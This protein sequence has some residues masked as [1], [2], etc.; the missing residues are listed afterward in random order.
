MLS[1]EVFS[2]DCCLALSRRLCKNSPTAVVI[3][4]AA[5]WRQLGQAGSLHTHL[6][7]T[8][9]Q[10]PTPPRGGERR[11]LVGCVLFSG[12]LSRSGL[13]GSW[14]P[15]QE[16]NS[17][18]MPESRFPFQQSHLSLTHPSLLTRW[19]VSFIKQ[20]LPDTQRGE[21]DRGQREEEKERVNEGKTRQRV[22]GER[23]REGEEWRMR[24][25]VSGERQRN[26]DLGKETCRLCACVCV[27][28]CVNESFSREEWVFPKPLRR[29][30]WEGRFFGD[31]REDWV[32]LSCVLM[33]DRMFF[34]DTSL[35]VRRKGRN[36]LCEYTGPTSV[37]VL[38]AHNICTADTLRGTVEVWGYPCA[39]VRPYGVNV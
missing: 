37:L 14:N 4:A 9:S 35:G 15:I 18:A 33:S 25:G 13:Q 38:C 11:S 30:V 6:P 31:D 3:D 20:A 19:R 5:L 39:H 34:P 8:L 2:R 23:Q 22:D 16:E 12:K 28:V 17:P 32:T 21:V 29:C 36:M 1:G 27:C 24:C 26:G 7:P 10:A